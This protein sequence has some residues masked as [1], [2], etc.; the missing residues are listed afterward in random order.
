MRSKQK[1]RLFYA[2][3]KTIRIISVFALLLFASAICF[4]SFVVETVST[5]ERANTLGVSFSRETVATNQVE[6]SFQYVPKGELQAVV[7]V[8]L[9]IS[10]RDRKLLSASLSPSKQAAD[11]VVYRFTIDPA[12]LTGSS[13]KVCFKDGGI[14]PYGYYQFAVRDFVD[15]D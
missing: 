12:Y 7:S 6:V 13:L 5:K 10:T 14:P 4:G 3:M 8:T 1:V 2:F 9:D 15:H 11:L